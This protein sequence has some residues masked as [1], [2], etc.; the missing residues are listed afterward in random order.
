MQVK[1]IL[2]AGVTALALVVAP[3]IALGA[4]ETGM[5]AVRLMD[6]GKAKEAI[7]IFERLAAGGDTRAMVQLGIYYYEG[8]EVD[9]DYT[10][11]M[12]WW[13]QGFAK[14]NADAFVNLGVMYRDGHGVPMNKKI[15]YCVFLTTHMCGLG[16]ESTQVRSNS[17]LR[18]VLEELSKDEIKDCLSNYTLSYMTAY[19]EARGELKGIPD[20]HKPS[21]ENP[22]LRDLDWWMDSEIDAIYGAPTEQEKKAREEKKI[23]RKAEIDALRHTL[24]F[25]IRFSEDAAKQYRSCGMITDQGMDSGPISAE[26]LQKQDERLVYEGNDMICANQHRYVSIENDKGETMDFRIDH[27]V[28]PSPCDWGQWQKPEY[29]LKDG[30]DKFTLLQGGEPKSKTTDLSPDAPELRFKVVKE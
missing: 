6:Q 13:L 11:A 26:K 4:D 24:V 18:R 8:T 2:M 22:A 12:D 7:Q 9:Q 10:K 20:E 16:S 27:P 1:H 30:M 5:D 17:C 28:T 14:Q 3:A 21:K 15:A 29:V 19:L 23:Q 25:Q